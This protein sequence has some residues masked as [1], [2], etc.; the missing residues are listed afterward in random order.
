MS[1]FSSQWLV[2]VIA[3]HPY[4]SVIWDFIRRR[5]CVC[6]CDKRKDC[7]NMKKDEIA[8]GCR[9]CVCYAWDCVCFIEWLSIEYWALSSVSKMGCRDLNAL[10]TNVIFPF[11]RHYALLHYTLAVEME[12]HIHLLAASYISIT[13]FEHATITPHCLLAATHHSFPHWHIV[14]KMTALQNGWK[15]LLMFHLCLTF[16]FFRVAFH[17]NSR[18]YSMLSSALLMRWMLVHDTVHVVAANCS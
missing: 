7:D 8:C 1:G 16:S 12:T 11:C 13:T 9:M 4:S 3:L 17:L 14:C 5:T 2:N 6:S 18:L 15:M 10:L